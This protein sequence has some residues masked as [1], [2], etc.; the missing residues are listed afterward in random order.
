MRF[1]ALAIN[2]FFSRMALSMSLFQI[3]DGERKITLGRRQRAMAEDFLDVAQVGLVLQKMRGATVPP[4]MTGDMLFH[5][6]KIRILFD[7]RCS[8]K[9]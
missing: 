2:S 1:L 3:G 8:C 6:R 4:Q 7:C 9:S 5:S